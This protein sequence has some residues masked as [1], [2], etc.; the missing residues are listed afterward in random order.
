MTSMV[1]IA[2]LAARSLCS[3]PAAPT[4]TVTTV[5]T[6][7]TARTTTRRAS[8]IRRRR[9]TAVRAKAT[10]AADWHHILIALPA[11]LEGRAAARR[12]SARSTPSGSPTVSQA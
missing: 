5:P 4:P 8:A 12:V 2:G 11:G 7:A 3:A 9:S 10:T 1:T 6:T